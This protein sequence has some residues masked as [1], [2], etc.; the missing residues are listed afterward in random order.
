M[1]ELADAPAGR[2]LTTRKPYLQL[3][4]EGV[5][6]IDVRVGSP[7]MRAIQ[8]GEMVTFVAGDQRLPAK[9]TR[10]VEYASFDDM[11]DHEDPEAIGGSLGRSRSQLLAVIRSIYPPDQERLGALAIHLNVG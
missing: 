4:A 5:K 1:S 6:T 3:I 2:E 8:A 7:E 11:L 10:I 9:V